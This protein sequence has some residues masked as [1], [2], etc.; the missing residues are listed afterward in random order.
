[1]EVLYEYEKYNYFA[2]NNWDND[3][4]SNRCWKHP[5]K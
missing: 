1:M 5:L 2:S 3:L 4:F